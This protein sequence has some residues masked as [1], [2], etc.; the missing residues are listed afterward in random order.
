MQWNFNFMSKSNR[1]NIALCW[2][3]RKSQPVKVIKM[4]DTPPQN[5]GVSKLLRW[6]LA[7]SLALAW[8]ACR[9]PSFKS[10]DSAPK[11]RKMGLGPPNHPLPSL[12][13]N[14]LMKL[15]HFLPKCT[16]TEEALEIAVPTLV[17]L[18]TRIRWIH[19]NRTCCSN[20]SKTRTLYTDGLRQ[21]TNACK[22]KS[23]LS[24]RV[25]CGGNITSIWLTHEIKISLHGIYKIINFIS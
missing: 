3:Q 19:L 4:F 6:P 22:T 5:P 13:L 17:E 8:R 12:I 15:I 18:V 2:T 20:T 7:R 1:C 9:L 11:K 25:G 24:S 16:I 21:D 14:K 23:R 10:A